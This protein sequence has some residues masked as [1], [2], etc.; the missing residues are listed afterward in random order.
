MLH[1]LLGQ[2]PSVTAVGEIREVWNRGFGRNY[3]CGCGQLFRECPVWTAVAEDAFGGMATV[4]HARLAELTETF[5]TKDLPLAPLPVLGDRKLSQVEELTRALSRLYLSI[6]EVTGS[7]VIVDSSK[8]ASFGYLVRQ[9]PDVD[10]KVLH[11]VR[12]GRAVAY[13]WSQRRESQPGKELRRQ[14]IPFSSLQW[15]AR[16]ATTELF[17]RSDYRRLRYEDF[18][19]RPE[20]ELS[21]IA[22]WI[23]RDSAP[24][25]VSGHTAYLTLPNHSVFGNG[26]RFASG[27]IALEED[28]RWVSEMPSRERRVASALTFPMRLRYGY[29]KAARG[30]EG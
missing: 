13:S 21:S 1:N 2:L 30:R 9:L 15:N 14:S 7:Q 24:L 26:V 29:L 8:N 17:L 5:R 28:R 19:S 12:D 16:N 4:P 3:L 25:P 11:L 10:M 22:R 27:E 18:L 6:A 23:G 20:A